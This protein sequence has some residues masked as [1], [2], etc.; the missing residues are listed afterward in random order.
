MTTHPVLGELLRSRI[1]AV[2]RLADQEQLVAAAKA[3]VRG[4]V[5]CIEVTL[6]TPGAQQIIEELSNDPRITVGAGTVLTRGQAAE[7]LRSG[8][9]FLVSPTIDEDVI[10]T[11]KDANV[12]VIPGA[13]TPNEI[14]RAL[15][16]NVDIIKLFPG[17][18]ATPSYFKDVLGPLPHARLMPTGNVNTETIPAYFA[19]GA[20]AVGVGKA[21]FHQE[22][23][24]QQDW[25]KITETARTYAELAQGGN[26]S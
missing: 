4:G 8:A 16:L 24:D 23:M 7:S 10:R 14:H 1:V 25:A 9:Q 12:P 26:R 17:Q 20:V 22:S 3:L 21:L 19:A 6:T 13:L 15:S 5:T 18:V 11:A 2:A